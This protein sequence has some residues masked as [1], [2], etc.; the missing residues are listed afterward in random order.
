M[1]TL[2]TRLLGFFSSSG[3]LATLFYMIGKRLSLTAL[4]IPLQITLIGALFV[5]RI[6][7]FTGIVTLIILV[8]N[9]VSFVISSI[10]SYAISSALEVPF[11]ILQS[12]GFIRALTETFSFFSMVFASLL[13]AFIS[14]M[15]VQSLQS[16]SDEY[17]KLGVLLQLGL[18]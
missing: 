12:I 7:L 16:I 8:Y 13:L 6:T 10:E 3:P 15:V 18:K 1:P 17:Y 4:I 14:K 9:K 11:L 5:G 2:I